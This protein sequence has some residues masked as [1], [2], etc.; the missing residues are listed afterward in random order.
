MFEPFECECIFVEAKND[1][2]PRSGRVEYRAATCRVCRVL[3]VGL[4][5]GSTRVAVFDSHAPKYQRM[6]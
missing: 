5:A 4:L 1:S 2:V 6:H 3:D